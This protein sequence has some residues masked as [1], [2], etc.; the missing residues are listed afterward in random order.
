[1][2]QIKLNLLAKEVKSSLLI[3]KVADPCTRATD[4]Y[5][6][7]NEKS[8]FLTSISPL[9]PTGSLSPVFPEERPLHQ[10]ESETAPPNHVTAASPGTNSR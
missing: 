5:S 7:V 2:L 9:Q 8:P 10:A 1:M 3:V 6:N 4:M